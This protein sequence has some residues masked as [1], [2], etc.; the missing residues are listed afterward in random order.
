MQKFE[1]QTSCVATAI[2]ISD[3][4]TMVSLM[5][6]LAREFRE[7]SCEI[8]E[9]PGN[10]EAYITLGYQLHTLEEIGFCTSAPGMITYDPEYFPV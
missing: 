8:R 6:R 4:V 1:H 3:A 5:D 2:S 10:L 7:L 9:N